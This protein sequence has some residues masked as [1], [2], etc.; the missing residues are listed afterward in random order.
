MANAKKSSSL[1]RVLAL[2]GTL[3]RTMLENLTVRL[4]RERGFFESVFSMLHEGVL[5]VD[6]EGVVEYANVA[7]EGLLGSGEEL[8][9]R[10]LWKLAPDLR[11][12]LEAAIPEL[13]EGSVVTREVDVDYPERRSLRAHAVA[14]GGG[15]ARGRFALT[16][17]DVTRERMSTE[18]RI[19]SERSA[20]VLLLAAS[21]AH[22]L[23]NPLNSLGIHL[24]LLA[25]RL[26]G[27]DLDARERDAL[28]E[29]VAVCQ[30]EVGRLD[31]IVRNFLGAVKPASMQM[32]E[33]DLAEVLGEVLSFQ[34]L[35]LSGRGVSLDVELPD[36][37]PS[38]LGD[39]NQI[40]QVLFNVSKNAMEAMED[41]GVLR[42][43]ARVDDD[44]V[45]LLVGD[46]GRGIRQEDLAN[47]FSPFYTTKKGGSGLGLLIVQRIMRAH[48]GQV[49]IESKAGV[50]TVV[51]L[52]FPRKDKRVRMLR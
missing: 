42:I 1:E 32:G 48:G 23:G 12:T 5:V 21:V 30:A 43:R 40:K 50:G 17:S 4:A 3:D 14:F 11:G 6:G 7:A 25:R 51:T 9:G 44:C 37:L 38:V 35:E 49:G 46:S 27:V 20:S 26:R 36:K 22:E 28:E 16:L 47:L 8:E 52:Q 45:C 24:Q 31:E 19:E 13:S 29:S 15:D 33:T 2:T 18:Q 39:K 34:E 10:V 41:G